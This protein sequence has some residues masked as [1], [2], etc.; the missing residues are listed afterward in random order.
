MND[1]Q[2]MIHVERI[3]RP[4]HADCSKLR[5]RTELL[6]H[7]QTA[8]EEERARG[9]D[10]AAALAEAKRR[11]GDPAELTRELQAAVPRIERLLGHLAMTQFPGAAARILLVLG[12]AL[13]LVLVLVLVPAGFPLRSRV[14]LFAGIAVME[15]TT[16]LWYVFTIAFFRPRIRWPRVV[17]AAIA[18]IIAQY[19]WTTLVTFALTGR[20]LPAEDA[21][22]ET[23]AQLLLPAFFAAGGVVTL[24][25]KRPLKQWLELDIA[26]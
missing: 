1:D 25:A 11:L 2:L 23:L 19:A 7:L 12:A 26:D 9:L 10:E 22:Q 5:M 16:L 17:C 6:A 13:P 24:L 20:V 21:V 4:I 14:I 18:A 15:L 8:F 3:V